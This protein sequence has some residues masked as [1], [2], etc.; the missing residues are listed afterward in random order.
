M[1]W[2]AKRRQRLKPYRAKDF[3]LREKFRSDYRVI[4]QFLVR[5]LSFDSVYDIGCANGFLLGEFLAADK[6]CGG[7]ELAPTVRDVLPPELQPLVEVGD[8][9]SA[10]GQWDLVCCVEVAEHIPPERSVDLVATVTR[11]AGSWIYFTA[12][13][14][15]QTGRGHINCRPHQE[16]LSWFEEAGWQE[17]DALTHRLR[18]ELQELESAPWLRSN[19]FVLAKG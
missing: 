17:H 15:G 4:G 7:I 10:E 13:P 18:E 14:P 8:F 11:L 5:N 3:R 9:S 2:L 12:A 16:W 6:R 19:S 1:S